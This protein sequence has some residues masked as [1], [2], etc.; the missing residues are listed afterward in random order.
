MTMER[1]EDRPTAVEAL[2][3]FE[4]MAAAL[5]QGSL[6]QRLHPLTPESWLTSIVRDFWYRVL[7]F[8]WRMTAPSP[9]RLGSAL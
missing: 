3:K 9:I 7:D 2:S 4:V 6:S 5:D 1:P 8:W